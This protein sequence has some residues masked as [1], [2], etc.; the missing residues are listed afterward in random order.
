MSSISLPKISVQLQAAGIVDAFADRRDLL[1]G[2]T[3]YGD[4]TAVDGQL[5]TNVQSMSVTDIDTLFG[6]R[7]DLTNRI[8]RHRAGNGGVSVLDVI[9][10]VVADTNTQASTTITMSYIDDNPSNDTATGDATLSIDVIDGYLYNATVD[11]VEDDTDAVIFNKI[12]NAINGLDAHCPVTA[13]ATGPPEVVTV[14]VE[15]YGASFNNPVYAIKI[16]CIVNGAVSTTIP[17]FVA[18]NAPVF[19]GGT[20]QPTNISTIFNGVESIR[21]NGIGWPEGWTADVSYVQDF[22]E[23][24]F[25][26]SGDILRGVAFLG[27]SR[28]YAMNKAYTLASNSRVVYPLGN[29]WLVDS[30]P[31]A[32]AYYA[33]M[34]PADYVAAYFM[35]VRSRRLTPGAQIADNIATTSGRND[36][37]GGPHMASLPYFN[38]PLPQVVPGD[39][40]EQY[41]TSDQDELA[42]SGLTVFGNNPT[43]TGVIMGRVVCP[44][45]TDSGGNSNISF[46]KL[47]YFDTGDVCSEIL[48]K[49]SKARFSQSRLTSGDAVPGYSMEN[50]ATIKA[51]FMSIYRILADNVLVAKGSD[52]EKYVSDNLDITIDIPNGK[53][54]V[55]SVLPIIVGL[56]EIDY[57]LQYSFGIGEGPQ[58]TF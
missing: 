50:A 19:S 56:E 16:T 36:S 7:S 41:T 35:G 9:P 47:N 33:I 46:H 6:P 32:Y 40:S 42:A 58:I 14:T 20:G 15:G 17:G 21:Y 44:Y 31:G 10:K 3:T 4:S 25:N 29:N 54:T 23:G 57:T 51:H 2:Q 13:T 30:A 11:V 49:S 48:Q 12:A 5:Y 22:L 52:A 38:T 27:S 24:R 1:V 37:R 18:I 8:L 55:Y 43:G 28:T 39:P 45:K 26:T 53:V 34:S